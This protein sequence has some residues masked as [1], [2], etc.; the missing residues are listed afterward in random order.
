MFNDL[1][2]HKELLEKENSKYLDKN[3]PQI[4]TFVQTM[5]MST[6]QDVKTAGFS[7]KEGP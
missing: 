1:H 3:Q 6:A 4:A 5:Q 2:H 7:G